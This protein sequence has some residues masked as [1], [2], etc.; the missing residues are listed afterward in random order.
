MATSLVRADLQNTGITHYVSREDVILSKNYDNRRGDEY[1]ARRRVRRDETKKLKEQRTTQKPI[2][3]EMGTFAWVPFSTSEAKLALEKR[4]KEVL[5]ADV[6]RS[7]NISGA[8]PIR[9]I[10]VRWKENLKKK[11]I[12]TILPAI[13]GDS[14][15]DS[16]ITEKDLSDMYDASVSHWHAAFTDSS[17]N[18]NEG[19]NYEQLEKLG[20]STAKLGLQENMVAVRP[21]I[22]EH[23]LTVAVNTILAKQ[24]QARV[25][26][27]LGLPKFLLSLYPD[28]NIS[29]TEDLFES[30]FGA[31]YVMGQTENMGQSLAN[32]FIWLL[33]ER[34]HI[35]IIDEVF[36]TPPKTQ[37]SNLFSTLGW[38]SPVEKAF[39]EGNVWR[40][41]IFVSDET[42]NRGSK[43]TLKL[44]SIY[45][46]R[47][48]LVNGKEYGSISPAVISEI[49]KSGLVASA[50][51]SNRARAIYNAYK[52]AVKKFKDVGLIKETSFLEHL[53]LDQSFDEYYESEFF[54]ALTKAITEGYENIF[55]TD[56]KP[57]EDNKGNVYINLIGILPSGE[58]RRQVIFT[59]T[60]AE[61]WPNTSRENPIL[62]N[63]KELRRQIYASY[64]AYKHTAA[65]QSRGD[66]DEDVTGLI[67]PGD[68]N[69]SD[70][71]TEE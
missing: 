12:S 4:Y 6:I 1:L 47:E 70:E 23:E 5:N 39:Q 51:G 28:V 24:E 67:R 21:T 3:Y 8:L 11:I 40:A 61:A 50:T 43:R 17:W 37:V 10:P 56:S 26:E 46:A 13:T 55:V 64:A 20:D 16:V 15:E 36:D 65:Y 27:E 33:N 48:K 7:G 49:L 68:E 63:K 62:S 60:I 25:S 44:L 58:E 31:L 54:A 9:K 66:D 41:Q 53:R 71:E 18:P 38:E 32:R 30:F 45:D 57:R 29:E 52:V 22:S 59:L 14:D 2:T 35:N 34:G 69:D 19:K 42:K